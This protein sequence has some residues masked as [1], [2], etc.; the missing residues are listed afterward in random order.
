MKETVEAHIH[1]HTQFEIRQK[2]GKCGEKGKNK[3]IRK[4]VT[5]NTDNHIKC[6]WSKRPN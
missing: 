3:Q 4:M 6:N 2:K 5:K 1:T